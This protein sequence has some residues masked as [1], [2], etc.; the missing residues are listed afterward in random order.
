VQRVREFA[1]LGIHR[2]V[3]VGA[4]KAANVRE[5]EAAWRRLARE[6]LAAVRAD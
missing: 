6:V 5:A 1:A 3:V 4:G 2:F